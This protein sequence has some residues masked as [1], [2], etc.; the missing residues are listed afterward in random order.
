MALGNVLFKLLR[1]RHSSLGVGWAA[2][3][4]VQAVVNC[5]LFIRRNRRE[6]PFRVSIISARCSC[7]NGLW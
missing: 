7:I 4:I 3:H 5:G 1:E 2:Y 6:I